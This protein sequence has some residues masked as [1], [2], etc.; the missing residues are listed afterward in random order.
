MD[1]IGTVT[2]VTVAA[3]V[4]A[5]KGS[6]SAAAAGLALANVFQVTDLIDS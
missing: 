5:S 6:V 2:I 3:V 4:V 1:L